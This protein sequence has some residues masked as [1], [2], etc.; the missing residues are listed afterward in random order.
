[1][2]NEEFR[3]KAGLTDRCAHGPGQKCL[4]CMPKVDPNEEIKGKCNHGP[5]GECPNYVD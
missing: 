5:V 4:Y 2:N 3:M 1:M